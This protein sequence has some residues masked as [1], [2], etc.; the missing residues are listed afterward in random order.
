MFHNRPHNKNPKS[1]AMIHRENKEN[2]NVNAQQQPKLKS[3]R[4]SLC[5]QSSSTIEQSLYE[6]E[7]DW[8]E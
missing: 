2:Q 3:R 6:R 7:K 1:Y 8:E 4:N 5:Q